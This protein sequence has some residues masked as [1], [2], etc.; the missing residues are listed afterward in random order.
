MSLKKAYVHRKS[1]IEVKSELILLHLK[2]TPSFYGSFDP[3][4]GLGA[5]MI[6]LKDCS[7]M[8]W[9]CSCFTAAQSSYMLRSSNFSSALRL[10]SVNIILI[11]DAGFSGQWAGKR[12]ANP[13]EGSLEGALA[14]FAVLQSFMRVYVSKSCCSI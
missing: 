6:K 2:G 3:C 8:T 7:T 10:C 14:P 5:K 12:K 11:I 4:F 9:C 1:E 13:T